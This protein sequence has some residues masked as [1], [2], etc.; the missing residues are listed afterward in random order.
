MSEEMT[1]NRADN[2]TA[3]P[4]SSAFAAEIKVKEI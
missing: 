4:Y 2:N 3:R 1:V